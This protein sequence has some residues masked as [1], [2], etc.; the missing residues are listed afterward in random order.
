LA[1]GEGKPAPLPLSLKLDVLIALQI[2]LSPWSP[3]SEMRWNGF[4]ENIPVVVVDASV[5]DALVGIFLFH[6]KECWVGS[7][8]IPV[9]FAASQQS[10]ELYGVFIALKRGWERFGG[11]FNLV[12]DSASSVSSV[13]KFKMSSLPKARNNLIRKIV[14]WGFMRDMKISMSWTD[15]KHN[16]ADIPSR[17][18]FNPINEFQT[19][20]VGKFSSYLAEAKPFFLSSHAYS[21]K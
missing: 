5:K 15:T 2:S 18:I 19:Y 3:D 13:T 7:F 1:A 4:Q 20:P 12:S 14:R 9:K 21:Q 10:A 11:V 16:L 17:E 8:A 6:N